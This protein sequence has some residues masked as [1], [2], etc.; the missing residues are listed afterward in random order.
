[1]ALREEG[2]RVSV[3]VAESLDRSVALG[4]KVVDV[5]S[6]GCGH[7]RWRLAP[8]R[9]FQRPEPGW[10]GRANKAVE[11]LR[12]DRPET[13]TNRARLIC[14]IEFQSCHFVVVGFTDFGHPL[15][16]LSQVPTHTFK[17]G[18]LHPCLLAFLEPAV[19]GDRRIVMLR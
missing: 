16:L 6:G 9:D 7:V 17:G 4:P 12:F 18:G 8:P 2:L 14:L 11:Y 1:M 19:V 5:K 15:D 10:A 3:G 13:G